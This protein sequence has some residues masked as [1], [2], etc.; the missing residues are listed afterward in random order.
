[1]RAANNK[2]P[3]LETFQQSRDDGSLDGMINDWA[4]AENVW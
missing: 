3:A 2:I 1:M 4:E